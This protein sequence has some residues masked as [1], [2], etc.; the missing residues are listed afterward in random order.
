MRFISLFLLF[1]LLIRNSKTE[2]NLIDFHE[3]EKN[4]PELFSELPRSL[5]E[6]ISSENEL[7][8]PDMPDNEPEVLIQMQEKILKSM[9][10]LTNDLQNKNKTEESLGDNNN[11]ENISNNSGF[12]LNFPPRFIEV[13]PS[14]NQQLEHLANSYEIAQFSDVWASSEYTSRSYSSQHNYPA[15]NAVLGFS[16]WCSAGSH[17][18]D[19]VKFN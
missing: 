17:S 2:S 14:S 15:I 18:S 10:L 19:Q 3:Y 7:S 5:S 9:G 16:Y 6:E 1:E 13:S 4:S 12:P 11:F 8:R